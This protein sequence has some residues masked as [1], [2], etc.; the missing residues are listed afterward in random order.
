MDK[1]IK[2]IRFAFI[3]LLILTGCGKQ[4]TSSSVPATPG[5]SKW[6]VKR[7]G[8]RRTWIA[9]WHNRKTERI[10]RRVNAKP[11]KR[12][13]EAAKAQKKLVDRHIKN[14]PPSV[15]E[16]MKASLKEAEKNRPKR[17]LRQRLR[18]WKYK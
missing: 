2:K 5:R 18:F 10:T 4:L 7:E 9:Y 3:V 17:T 12:E 13:K 16:R 14:Q 1:G 6:Q 11:V 15:Q 8:Y